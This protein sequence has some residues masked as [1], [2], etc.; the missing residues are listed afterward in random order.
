M[1]FELRVGRPAF[2]QTVVICLYKPQD[3]TSQSPVSSKMVG[4]DLYGVRVVGD[5]CPYK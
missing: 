3:D 2:K 5:L 4:Y 1:E